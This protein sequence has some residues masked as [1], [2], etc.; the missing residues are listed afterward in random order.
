MSKIIN[1]ARKNAQISFDAPDL[2]I[3][4]YGNKRFRIF[5]A[6]GWAG[7]I[8]SNSSSWQK[9]KACYNLEEFESEIISS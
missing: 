4:S 3:G 1:W 6:E 9:A 8:N 5:I 7:I 2:I